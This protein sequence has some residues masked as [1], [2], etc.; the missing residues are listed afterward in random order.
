MHPD[1]RLRSLAL[2]LLDTA[3]TLAEQQAA[4]LRATI[5]SPEATDQ[6]RLEALTQL[7]VL[8]QEIVRK[9]LTAEVSLSD[10]ET[11]PA[12]GEEGNRDHR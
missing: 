2:R 11:G 9:L 3:E 6:E 8:S 10:A 5:Q 7:A 1:N 12:L 4:P